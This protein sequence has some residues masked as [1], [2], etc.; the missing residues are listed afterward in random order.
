[1]NWPPRN[2]LGYKQLDAASYDEAAAEFD[3]ISERFVTPLAS[4]LLGLARLTPV[5]RVLDVGTGSGLVA[6]GA[7]PLVTS[8]KVVGIDHSPGMLERASAKA[9]RWGLGNNVS[10]RQMD[11]EK[12]EFP[13]RSFDK[14]LSLYAL[15]HFPE[16]LRALREMHRVLTPGGRLVIGVGSGPSP[17]SWSGVVQI[18]RRMVDFVGTARGRLLTAPDFL[19][20]L[21]VEHRMAPEEMHPTH[22]HLRIAHMLRQAAFA[23]IHR[24][25]QGR[26]EELDPMEFWDVQVV[27]ASAE[28]IR[29]QQASV[30]DVDAL[31]Q[32]F[33]PRCRR[34]RADGGKLIYRHA[35]MFYTATR[36]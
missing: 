6:L 7:A 23:R 19:H 2:L 15:L 26:R 28:R 11:A 10:F 27:Y 36:L 18:A 4:T 9:R 8:G 31:K 5:D 17:L 35:A 34:I 1:M 32:D 22:R 20:R 29:L 13:D 3:R 24:S 12:L 33:F 25:W 16:P 14:V 30:Q 21:M